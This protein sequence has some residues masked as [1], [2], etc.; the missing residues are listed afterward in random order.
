VLAETLDAMQHTE[1]HLADI[2][3]VSFPLTKNEFFVS[4]DSSGVSYVWD[5]NDLNVITKCSPGNMNKS[6][7]TCVAIAE[8]DTII[9][10]YTDGFV[11]AYT[12]TNKPYSPLKW[13][14]VNAHKGA[15]TSIFANA[16][17]LLSGG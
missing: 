16:N 4:I 12:I 13:E 14:I 11:R 17:Y 6:A 2:L 10:G 1:G 5:N 7:G 3:G 8:D 9:C 15:V